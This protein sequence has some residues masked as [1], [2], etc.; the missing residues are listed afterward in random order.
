MTLA[1]RA[2]LKREPGERA[3]ERIVAAFDEDG[4][5]LDL[6]PVKRDRAKLTLPGH[7]EGQ[8]VRVMH[9]PVEEGVEAPTLARLRRKLALEERVLALSDVTLELSPVLLRHWK[10]SCCRVRGRVVT[11]VRLPGGRVQERPLCNA[12]VVVCEVDASMHWIVKRLPNE[13]IYRL[14]DEWIAALQTVAPGEALT[15]ELRAA[16]SGLQLAL[17]Q[18]G[19]AGLQAREPLLELAGAPA[20]EQ[21]RAALLEH[22]QLLRPFWCDFDWLRPFYSLDCPHTVEVA[23]DGSFDTEVWYPCYGDRPDLY[24][25]VEQDCHPGGW[26]TVHAPPV[27]CNTYWDYCC[28]TPVRIEVTH[29]AAAPGRAPTLC[30]FPHDVSD[31]ASVGS[32]QSLPHTSGVF[33]VHAAL[34][35]NGKVLLFSGT[36]EAA[37]PTESRVWDPVTD[38]MTTQTFTDDLF[39]AG[40]AMLADGQVLVVGGSSTPG[41]GIKSAHIFNS[42]TESWA[43]VADMGFARWYPTAATLPDG[44]VM[45]FSGRNARPAVPEIEVY[46]PTTGTWTQLPA[47]ADKS[48][49][50]YPSVHVMPDGKILYTGTRWAGSPSW[51]APPSSELLDL[52]TNTWSG[53]DDHVIPN[54]TEAFSVLLPPNRPPSAHEMEGMEE[55]PPPPPTLSRVLVAG[56]GSKEQNADQR[57]AEIIDMAAPAPAWRR[58]ADMNFARTNV[59]GVLLPDGKVLFCSGIDGYKWDGAPPPALNAELFDPEAETWTVAAAMSVARQY[60]SISLLLADGRVLNTG[61]VG[62]PGGGTNL[63][64]MELYSPPYLHRSPRPQVTASPSSVGYGAAFTVSSPDAC[65]ID[66]VSLIRL[67][68]ITHH[69]NT[70][71][72]FLPLEFHRQGR[73][74]LRITAPA[75]ANVA[76][77][78]YYLLFVL[79][80]CEVPSVGRSVRI[81]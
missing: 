75:E 63:M 78:G 80:D 29:P 81:G 52:A 27:H 65:R 7:L 19:G 26:L 45:V 77:P 38:T 49:E 73:C 8:A 1:L 64:S 70:D 60:H 24:F 69:T 48:L 28:G 14:R 40:H 16:R 66:R 50:I 22:L 53:V 44:R 6:A 30:S 56:G 20:A 34:L 10:R 13:L 43:K 47:S 46:D 23:E 62:G 54:R 9:A 11:Q 67:T 37:L 39:C 59:N 71:Q 18:D 4:A 55:A 68:S 33:V 3:P 79:D 74:D 12:R 17:R 58:I 32:W 21:I 31:P 57:S 42:A 25:R 61:S 2:P 41:H 15:P 72:R 76:P 5:F 51:P 36:V 35:P